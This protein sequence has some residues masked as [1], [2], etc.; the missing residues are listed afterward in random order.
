MGLYHLSI[1]VLALQAPSQSEKGVVDSIQL[2]ETT[3]EVVAGQQPWKLPLE[4]HMSGNPQVSGLA[5]NKT[6]ALS[7]STRGDDLHRH[8]WICANI[9]T[10]W[11]F[12][13]HK[14]FS[15]CQRIWFCRG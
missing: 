7:I 15:K 9:T 5:T 11:I 1:A 10:Y 13:S 6:L 12:L 2:D 4:A 14:Y 8:T 3:Q